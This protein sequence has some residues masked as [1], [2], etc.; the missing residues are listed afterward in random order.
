MNRFEAPRITS[1]PAYGRR[2]S[3][4]SGGLG[5]S[6]W[7]GSLPFAG[8][9]FLLPPSQPVEDLLEIEE[10]LKDRV[11][12]LLDRYGMLFRE[13][14]DHEAPSFRW[15]RV[16]RALRLMELSSEVLS[17]YFFRDIPGPQFISPRAFQVLQGRL[18]VKKIYWLN[19][20]DPASLCGVPLVAIKGEMP[21]RL[22]GNH[23]VYQGSKL[24][25][26]SQQNGRSLTIKVPPEDPDLTE[27]YG[28]L[29]HLLS[30][31]FQ[32]LRRINIDTI[33]GEAAVDS[34]Y[35]NSLKT[36]FDI[37]SHN[38]GLIIYRRMNLPA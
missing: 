2:S 3:Q 31:Q 12:L 36:N 38:E 26:I 22:P 16:F 9:W 15:S 25:I 10:Q 17:G 32:P 20:V 18:P 21:R 8:N 13:L 4:R 28:F 7:K 30:R 34:P 23:I 24:V 27:F 14:L 37:M 19:A 29:R 1:P 35:L 6:R 33:N 5:F 11:R